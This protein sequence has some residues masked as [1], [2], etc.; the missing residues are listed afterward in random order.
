MTIAQAVVEVVPDLSKFDAKARAGITDALS[1]AASSAAKSLDQI[2]ESAGSTGSTV[3][4]AF[5]NA[6]TRGAES[7][8]TVGN[9]DFGGV[10]D[11]AASSANSV[12]TAFASAGERA[13]LSM[14]ALAST[15]GNIA[16]T[17]LPRLL[18]TLTKPVTI[19]ITGAASL[20]Q[21]K[22]GFTSLYGS[23]E[24]AQ[25]QIESFQAF[26]AVTPFEFPG[27]IQAAQKMK[28][29]GFSADSI[30]PNLTAIGDVA[31][32]L[33]AP[34]EAI[35]GVVFAMSQMSG[36]GRVM[37][38]DLYQMSNALPG[39]NAFKAIGDQLGKTQAEVR[40]MV[41]KGLIPADVGIQAVLDGMRAFPGAAGAM[42]RQATTL[43]GLMSTFKDTSRQA[44]VDGLQP[45][46]PLLKTAIGDATPIIKGLIDAFAAPIAKIA[47]SVLP[48]LMDAIEALTPAIGV[49]FDGLQAVFDAIGPLIGKMAEAFAP[50]VEAI[51]GLMSTV[52][53]PLATA[54]GELVDM[55]LP[56]MPVITEMAELFGS[57]LVEAIG[58]I[59]PVL[60]SEL[61]PV[62]PVIAEAF[63]DVMTALA[64]LLP[65]LARMVADLIPPFVRVLELLLPILAPLVDILVTG[66]AWVLDVIG[67]QLDWIVPLVI[68]VWAA[69]K[70]WTGVMI[71]AR[72]A[73]IAFNVVQLA[74][75][76]IMAMN[77]IVL[78]VAAIAALSAALVWAY[79][80]FDGFREV[81]D[82]VWQIMQTAWNWI[83]TVAVSIWHTLY[84]AIQDVVGVATW[85][86]R[87]VLE[88]FGS[89][90]AAAFSVGL[91]VLSTA[92]DVASTAIGAV[93]TAASWLWNNV[94][95]PLATF[96]VEVFSI[97][98][99]VLQV[100]IELFL[101]PFK[102]LW[103]VAGELYEKILLPLAT[104]LVD[105][106]SVAWTV[107][108]TA[109]GWLVK[110][111][112]WLWRNVLKPLWDTVLS[113]LATFLSTVLAVAFDLVKTAVQG[114]LDTLSWLWHHILEPIVS[115]LKDVFVGAVGLVVDIWDGLSDA[116]GTV[117]DWLKDIIK[118]A[119]KAVEWLGKI[120]PLS[121]T[122]INV[123]A[124]IVYDNLP[125]AEQAKMRAAGYLPGGVKPPDHADGGIFR[126]SS[127]GQ[128]VRIAEGGW[129]QDE[130]VVPLGR[131]RQAAAILEEAGL[132]GSS[133]SSLDAQTIERLAAAFGRYVKPQQN[134]DPREFG[135]I[136]GRSMA[137]VFR[138]QMRAA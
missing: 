1:R 97:A 66:L 127:H 26:A 35:N 14:M 29:V 126:G 52:L 8:A 68:G 57:V 19:G 120:N 63:K 88:P 118:F 89:F 32:T 27:L 87:N 128:I 48:P 49:F 85:L 98:W 3:A 115:F 46:I 38:E 103:T 69:M 130:A 9:G 59:V 43:N 106:F 39:F 132:L 83:T 123:S 117:V 125:P 105:V 15:I 135:E 114:I 31:A 133:K 13:N 82:A 131:P 79:F 28:A 75:N 104:F 129:G 10:S 102:I 101:V 42:E 121:S 80:K 21:L 23:A 11:K 54:F 122:K 30:I 5:A 45:M 55:V 36:A 58:E 16:A 7:L 6:S 136:A 137:S 86:W 110:A 25:K 67:G 62:L 34:Q 99:S 47:A 18:Q 37:T 33:G 108:T 53:P 12:A 17:A 95:S 113:P 94:L 81:V 41:S 65:A 134:I 56:L 109:I 50:F 93:V 84:S 51:G 78:V 124:D 77:P 64:P 24:E 90:L 22:I 44:L 111:V 70:L 4:K 74:F 107:V 71:A 96:L 72:V 138:Q 92:F 20:E 60:L 73:M 2:A 61:K 76:A 40:D 91:A 100:A 119:E 116:L 112:E